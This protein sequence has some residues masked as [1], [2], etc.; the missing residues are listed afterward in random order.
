VNEVEGPTL[1]FNDTI[2][3]MYYDYGPEVGEIGVAVNPVG[4][5]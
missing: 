4:G 2:C 5:K 3:L 1:V